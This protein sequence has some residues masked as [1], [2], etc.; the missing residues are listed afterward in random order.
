[1][2]GLSSPS[3]NSPLVDSSPHN[4]QVGSGGN[5]SALPIADDRSSRPHSSSNSTSQHD[6]MAP[7]HFHAATSRNHTL[8]PSRERTPVNRYKPGVAD[9]VGRDANNAKADRATTSSSE[10][11]GSQARS[12]SISRSILSQDSSL[13]SP[14][15][16]LMTVAELQ[17]HNYT[18]L[19]TSPAEW[20]S[21][22]TST[23]QLLIAPAAPPTITIS[24]H[25]LAE[26]LQRL[27][28]EDE[29]IFSERIRRFSTYPHPTTPTFP[30]AVLARF[31][32]CM[33][34]LLKIISRTQTS[35]SNDAW[36]LRLLLL[37]LPRLLLHVR[38]S[39][40]DRARSRK[41][42]AACNSFLKGN[43]YGRGSRGLFATF[44]DAYDKASRT[45]SQMSSS[46][47][48]SDPGP[49]ADQL[50]R[51]VVLARAG[52]F[53][54]AVRA[55]TSPGLSNLPP[56][57]LHAQLCALHPRRELPTLDPASFDPLSDM[58]REELLESEVFTSGAIRRAING[59]K[60]RSAPDQFGWRARELLGQ[61]FFIHGDLATA[62]AEHILLPLLDN[63]APS[64]AKCILAGGTLI[65][66][67]K[68]AHKTGIR[69]I[70]VGD[71][72][73]KIL[74]RLLLH[75]NKNGIGK[76][77]STTY[78]NYVQM[79]V[80]VPGGTE[81][82]VHL[83]ML[84]SDLACREVPYASPPSP[85]DF[86]IAACDN[87][88]GFN[89]AMRQLAF[90]CWQG[91]A[92]RQYS[93]VFQEGDA[94]PS[95]ASFLN[96]P[97][98]M[99]AFLISLYGGE[100]TYVFRGNDGISR[101]VPSTGGFHQGCVLSSFM[102]SLTVFCIIG[103]LLKS[104]PDVLCVSYLDN[105]FFK[106]PFN[107]VL[108][109]LALLRQIFLD[110][111]TPLNP[112]DNFI[113]VPR[114]AHLLR[115]QYQHVLDKLEEA[116]PGVILSASCTSQ[117]AGFPVVVD[118]LTPLGVPIGTDSHIR[119]FLNRR[120]GDLQCA[121]KPLERF[122]DGRIWASLLRSCICQMPGY[123]LRTIPPQ[124]LTRLNYLG[125][126]DDMF[127]AHVA[128]Y[129][130]WPEHCFQLQDPR[131]L[132]QTSENERKRYGDT[133]PTLPI[134][135]LYVN[136]LKQL[137]NPLPLGGIGMNSAV[138]L[139]A[140]AF[141]A[142]L[143]TSIFWIYDAQRQIYRHPLLSS[144]PLCATQPHA[145]VVRQSS[146]LSGWDMTRTELLSLRYPPDQ[147]K[148]DEPP[149]YILSDTDVT[150]N[151]KSSAKH[152]I[153]PSLGHLTWSPVAPSAGAPPLP[154]G[155]P[156]PPQRTLTKARCTFPFVALPP[157]PNA[158]A[159]P[160]SPEARVPN[161][162][163]FRAALG[164]PDA[165]RNMSFRQ[166]ELRVAHS[167]ATQVP[168]TAPFSSKDRTVFPHDKPKAK[169]GSLLQ[170]YPLSFLAVVPTSPSRDAF[171]RD[172]FVSYLNMFLGLPRAR[173][174]AHGGTLVRGNAG[175]HCECGQVFDDMGLH[176]LTCVSWYNRTSIVG[177]NQVLQS[178]NETLNQFGVP[179][180]V[181]DSQI[182][183]TETGNPGGKG[184]RADLYIAKPWGTG[185]NH[186]PRGTV[187]DLSITHPLPA[188]GVHP[189]GVTKVGRWWYNTARPEGLPVHIRWLD[190][191]GKHAQYF[192]HGFL[193]VPLIASTFGHLHP[194]FLRFLWHFS[195]VDIDN[196]PA[197]FDLY[198]TGEVRH[199]YDATDDEATRIQ[200]AIFLKLK[201][202]ITSLVARSAASRMLGY[203][204]ELEIKHFHR[205]LPSTNARY[206]PYS[207][208]APSSAPPGGST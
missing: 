137:R 85:D 172:F 8:S 111:G 9:T 124:T 43:L 72:A 164:P 199:G 44:N 197:I 17:L 171:P 21:D 189:D 29:Q 6:L 146:L 1:M 51:S 147:L 22:S 105:H 69:P 52:N 93:T 154:R 80:G 47:P 175:T 53:G 206:D 23:P 120:L 126:I 26:A 194:D 2:S 167:S 83:L 208:L 41:A 103:E 180:T 157:D 138:T 28:L 64:W 71:M 99:H 102:F 125:D 79:G 31:G 117:R 122:P 196:N 170:S 165:Q 96:H 86:V 150:P 39:E 176:A 202:R 162:H 42:L 48:L 91:K 74:A 27:L 81:K 184:I 70:G 61:V 73:R 135:Y 30:R 107:K 11:S 36:R 4:D 119:T 187:A 192:H 204:C 109:V 89:L 168:L 190:K 57:E 98:A 188:S 163:H 97:E 25:P 19:L 186:R 49:S 173:L 106:G 110:L 153:L 33:S 158:P 151:H 101:E 104:H 181:T 118:G 121:M 174:L 10:P 59:S 18:V 130:C 179:C 60:N 134:S 3:S 75:P 92:S 40:C 37:S 34:Q 87:L 63:S 66:L 46:E 38:P 166:N 115:P 159:L 129:L 13:P 195:R 24:Y 76:Y 133:G 203:T 201:A 58:H 156:P 114:W 183:R 7:P 88:N 116:T 55:L 185:A 148:P 145:D 127:A 67:S 32:D 77:F 113:Y 45:S 84:S 5:S 141:F 132:L 200:K 198:T 136:A 56:E 142:A 95:P 94:M 155:E 182:P 78:P 205:S 152:I 68:G 131:D 65:P 16:T 193:M 178:L 169:S 143:S 144:L 160:T 14:N 35:N 62:W 50:H 149:R 12:R 15:S 20:D 128:K 207:L 108:P 100:S 177:H 191:K 161:P 140:P 90:D 112:K 82:A 54:G 123:H 139:S